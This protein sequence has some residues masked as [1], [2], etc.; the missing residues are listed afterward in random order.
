MQPNAI[1]VAVHRLRHQYREAL[2]DELGAGDVP[3]SQVDE[4]LRHLA[5]ALR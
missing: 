4:E 2:R 5:A 3:A 1:G